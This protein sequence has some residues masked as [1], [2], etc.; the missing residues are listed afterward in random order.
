MFLAP[1]RSDLGES[2]PTINLLGVYLGEL[3]SKTPTPSSI[4]RIIGVDGTFA[5][6]LC[7][8]PD[9][10]GIAMTLIFS[11]GSFGATEFIC[12]WSP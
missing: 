11:A 8:S 9:R 4:G 3:A 2:L 6:N 1:S 12:T 10:L 7:K 5:H